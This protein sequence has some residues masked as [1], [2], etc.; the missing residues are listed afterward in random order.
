MKIHS[1]EIIKDSLDYNPQTGLF[2][3]KVGWAKGKVAGTKDKYIRIN[4]RKQRYNAQ[5]LALYYINEVW[6]DNKIIHINGN[7]LDN[8]LCNL[9]YLNNGDN[10]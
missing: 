6:S 1:I 4:I 10:K 5:Q 9:K 7:I 2:I 3:W 8:R